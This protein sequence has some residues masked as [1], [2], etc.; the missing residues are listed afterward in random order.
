MQIDDE[1]LQRGAAEL[2]RHNH[3]VVEPGG[4]AGVA[5]LGQLPSGNFPGYGDIV[6]I[7]T[8]GNADS[9]ELATALAQDARDWGA[10]A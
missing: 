10:N 4:P 2:M 1:A 7:V 8:G 9:E 6:V 3:V 5:I